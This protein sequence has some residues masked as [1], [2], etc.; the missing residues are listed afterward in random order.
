MYVLSID[1]GLKNLGICIL[2]DCRNI[3]YWNVLETKDIP[4]MIKIIDPIYLSHIEQIN[5]VLI[6]KQ[7]SFNPKMRNISSAL[8]SYFI[9]RGQVDNLFLKKI[10]FYS[11][12]LKLQLCEDH[13]SLV[14]VPKNKRYRAHKKM[15]INQTQKFISGEQLVFFNTHKKK[16]D[17][18][19]CYLQ[20]FWYINK[21]IIIRK[22]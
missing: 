16:D 3:I 22:T 12:K 5:T 7:P 11:P 1:V 10:I 4:D 9:I 2:D 6:E 14:N 18:S 13:N 15:A 20:G 19:D 17:L 8:Y 21:Y